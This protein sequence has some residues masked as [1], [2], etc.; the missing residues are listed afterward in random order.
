MQKACFYKIFV[1]RCENSKPIQKQIVGRTKKASLPLAQY[2][3]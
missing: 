3:L 1:L 2:S